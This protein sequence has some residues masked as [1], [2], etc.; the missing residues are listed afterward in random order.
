MYAIYANKP[1]AGTEKQYNALYKVSYPDVVNAY[2]AF[3]NNAHPDY[4]FVKSFGAYLYLF[5]RVDRDS[6][7]AELP[8]NK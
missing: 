3:K 2:T 4:R 7:A 1:T 8:A 6:R 5:E